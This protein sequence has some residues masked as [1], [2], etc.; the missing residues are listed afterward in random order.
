MALNGWVKIAADD[1][2]TVVMPKSE[3]GQ[4][5]HT[6]LA[7]VLADELDADWSRVGIEASPIDDIYNNLASV[8]DGLPFHPDDHGALKRLAGWMTAKTMREI[9]IM[10]TGGSSSIKDLWLPMRQAGAS[11]RAMLVAAAAQAWGVPAGEVTLADGVLAHRSGKRARLGEFAAAAAGQPLPTS[12]TLKTPAQFRLIGQPLPRLATEAAAKGSG[13]A[14][15]GIDVLPPGLLY[16][17]VTMC[18]TLGGKV[19]SFD[20]AA[21]LKLPGVKQA[22]AVAGHA[23]GTAGV[24]VIADTPWHAMKRARTGQRAMGPGGAGRGLF[25]RRRDDPAGADAGPRPRLRLPRGRRRRR[26][27]GLGDANDQRR[28]PR[29]LPGPR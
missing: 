26:G 27:A 19:A 22:L 1:R 8:V 7:M 11:A 18:P 15:F 16:A 3:M 21:A 25:E 20:A 29:A 12:P 10:M 6:G 24:A 9:G 4:G 23:G 14:G 28:V 17:S 13:R 5:A 2:V